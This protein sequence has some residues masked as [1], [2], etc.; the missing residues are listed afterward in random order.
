ME[1]I[2][3]NRLGDVVV[4]AHAH[5]LYR[6]VDGALS[7][8]HDYGHGVGLVC[9]AFEKFHSAHARHLEIGDDDGWGPLGDLF[10]SLVAIHGRFHPIAPCGDDLGKTSPFVLLVFHNQNF[11]LAH[12]SVR[13]HYFVSLDTLAR[14]APVTQN[15]SFEL[16]ASSSERFRPE[17]AAHSS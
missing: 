2:G 17:R 8:H 12:R 14:E 9:Q 13:H 6:A 11:F 15:L 16:R 3:V 10:P 5:R 7:R 4:G 1:T